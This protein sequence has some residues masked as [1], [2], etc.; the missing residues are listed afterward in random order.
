[1]QTY[2]GVDISKEYFDIYIEGT[3]QRLQNNN[4][5]HTKVL[6]LL[7]KQSWVVMECTGTYGHRLADTLV[8]H[9]ITVSMANALQVKRFAQSRSKRAKT[10]TIDAGLLVEYAISLEH[11]S[12]ER[13]RLRVWQPSPQSREYLQ[14]MRTCYDLLLRQRTMLINQMEGY[15][16]YVQ[17]S[18]KVEDVHGE[19]LCFLDDKVEELELAM[20]RI[21]E[22]HYKEESE[23]IES[24][25]GVGRKTSVAVIAAVGNIARFSSAKAL[26]AYCGLAPRII[27]SGSSV[28]GRGVLCSNGVTSLRT[29]LYMCAMS[30]VRWNEPCKKLYE[31]LVAKGK[32]KI[33]AL[34]AVAHKLVR[35][36]YA[37]L[38][39]KTTFTIN[40]YA[41]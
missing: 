7:P 28:R 10:D 6:S 27:Q 38:T 15:A 24:I 18:P 4:E 29:Q 41:C 40:T 20:N 30:A 11:C 5:G 26:A 17:V 39:Y 21:V 9:G 2:I 32:K 22:E 14:Q 12:D 25:P 33:V 13:D 37:V 1:M 34:L 19:L 23:H 36:I 8:A 31:R 16:G 3:S 35:Q